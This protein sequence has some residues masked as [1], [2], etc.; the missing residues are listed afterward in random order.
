[1]TI[2]VAE[3]KLEW[4]FPNFDCCPRFTALWN[5]ASK[6]RDAAGPDGWARRFRERLDGVLAVVPPEVG[7][8]ANKPWG[9]VELMVRHPAILC[10]PASL[11]R[12]HVSPV[13]ELPFA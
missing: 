7:K 2:H 1:M 13:T 11:A 9:V 3:E 5:E 10:S 8:V 4:L 6:R 12:S